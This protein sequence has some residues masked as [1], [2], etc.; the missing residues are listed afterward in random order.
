VTGRV[1]QRGWVARITAPFST[2][3]PDAIRDPL[4]LLQFE[5]L[6]ALTP[7][8]YF[9]IAANAFAM[10]LAVL[11]DLPLW[12]QLT[13]P[14]LVVAVCLWQV[15]KWHQRRHQI[16]TPERAYRHLQ[17]AVVLAGGIGLVSGIW[18]VSAFSETEKYFCL[19][20]PVFLAI[21]A[22]VSAN[23]LTSVPR[24]ATVAM[25]TALS[26]IVV[27]LLIFDNLGMRSIAVMLVLIAALQSRLVQLKFRETEKMLVLQHEIVELSEADPLTGLKNRRAFTALLQAELDGDH[28][29]T[30]A[31]LDLD[32]FKLAND[33]YGHH[34][35]DDVLISVAGRMQTA[36][37]S[38]LCVARLGGD[39]FALI[40]GDGV[41]AGQAHAEVEAIRAMIALP[42][43]SGDALIM[44]SASVGI[45]NSSDTGSNLSALLQ[46]ADRAL[47]AEKAVRVGKAE[48]RRSQINGARTAQIL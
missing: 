40:F 45:A 28:A 36:A 44:I 25:V 4:T 46:A 19:V 24:A 11:G 34:A 48:R 35:G 47:Y 37:V 21:T 27:R 23:C 9:T 5:R 32:G 20:A 17:K 42:H 31:M 8:L 14:V 13:P 3:I 18:T 16:T 10:T 12:Q 26:P 30:V 15:V 6:N 39:E 7:L 43:A 1:E 33:N 41:S 38:A 2:N 29:V 22:L